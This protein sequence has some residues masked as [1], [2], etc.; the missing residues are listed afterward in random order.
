MITV[1]SDLSVDVSTSTKVYV[2]KAMMR[3]LRPARPEQ[4]GEKFTAPHRNASFFLR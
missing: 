2:Q 1:R 3:Q 4:R